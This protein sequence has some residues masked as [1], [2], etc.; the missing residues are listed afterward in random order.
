MHG[1][2]WGMSLELRKYPD[3][4]SNWLPL[5]S[6]I[7]AQLLSHTSEAWIYSKDKNDLK[8]RFKKTQQQKHIPKLQSR[9]TESQFEEQILVY[10]HI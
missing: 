1:P 2:S 4:E 9:L 5:G 7:H 8:Q 3:Q 6:W 10:L